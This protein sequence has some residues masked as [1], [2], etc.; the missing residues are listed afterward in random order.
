MVGNAEERI[1]GFPCQLP[2]ALLQRIILSSTMVGD[3]VLDPM[4]GSGTTARVA[5]TERRRYIA[6][7][8]KARFMKIIEARLAND[9]QQRL[10]D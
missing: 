9:Y 8:R 6:I 2:E 10:F 5:L 7:E 1:R 3:L 4:S